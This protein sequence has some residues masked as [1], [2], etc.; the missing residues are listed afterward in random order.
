MLAYLLGL[1]LLA[2]W[3]GL[4]AITFTLAAAVLAW[5]AGWYESANLWDYL[6]DPLVAAYAVAALIKQGIRKLR[7][8]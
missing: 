1:A 3:Q 6:L 4:P 7:K 8:V 5:S 2:A